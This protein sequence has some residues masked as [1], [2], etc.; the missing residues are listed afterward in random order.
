MIPAASSEDLL[1]LLRSRLPQAWIDE[2][3]STPDGEAMLMAIVDM[4]ADV[5]RRDAERISALYVAPHSTQIAEP[6]SGARAAAV[7]LAI[8]RQRAGARQTVPVGT[9]VQT[10]DGHVFLTTAA[11]SFGAGEVGVPKLVGAV[12]LVPGDWATIPPGE[13]DE[14]TP[15]GSGLT[16]AGVAVTNVS[17]GAGQYALRFQTDPTKPH[18]WRASI[19]GLPVEIISGANAGRQSR[20]ERVTVAS[21][22]GAGPG[23]ETAFAWSPPSD[24]AVTPWA[25]GSVTYEWAIRDWGEIG[26]SV[27]NTTRATGGRDGVLDELAAARG[28]PRR[29]GEND[30]SVRKR[31]RR[32]PL[33][34]SALGI[35]EQVVLAITPYGFGRRDVRIYELGQ[36]P[37]GDASPL[38]ENFPA[39]GG[40]IVGLHVADMAAP[41]TPDAMARRTPSGVTLNTFVNPG[42]V[43]AYGASPWVVIVRLL[44][45][46]GFDATSAAVIRL[47]AWEA[48]QASRQGGCNVY[49][50]NPLQWGYPT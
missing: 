31:L 29:L 25:V 24:E 44:L 20:I 15:V 4:F 2:C 38:A 28:R 32:R 8:T 10:P 26:F 13:I 36:V 33:S 7:T 45:P 5:D 6:A 50:Y 39:S 46:A 42:F 19:T 11:L 47:A 48:T 34:P 18:P 43:G 12:A 3:L 22:Y 16:G 30:E 37:V 41:H 27:T 23:T 35:L 40:A 9:K 21:T 17:L 1:E 14:F 49:L